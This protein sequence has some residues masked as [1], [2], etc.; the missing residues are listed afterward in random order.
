MWELRQVDPGFDPQGVA[1]MRISLPENRYPEESQIAQFGTQ[2]LERINSI[3]GVES[4]SIVTWLPMSGSAAELTISIEGRSELEDSEEMS[5]GYQIVT[6]GYRSL[7]K[8]P[9]LKGRD[10]TELD[11][12]NTL[13]VALINETFVRR[14]FLDEDPID[15][16][17]TF[18]DP[19]D[20]ETEWTT[21]VGI[22]GDVHH[23]QL[24]RSFLF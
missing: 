19:S 1:V 11:N 10:F 5:S 17:F 9:L 20:D 22:V 13:E 14:F 24:D 23:F 7:M 2:L 8:I 4:S 3:P 12:E 21:I 6:P 18:G 16:R 15:K